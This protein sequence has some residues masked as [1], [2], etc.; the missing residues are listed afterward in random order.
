MTGAYHDEAAKCEEA[1][2]WFAA[3]VML[4]AALEGV[5]LV[6]ALHAEPELRAG[7]LWPRGDPLRWD[8]HELIRL[9]VA[10]NWFDADEVNAPELRL[11]DVVDA[12]RNLRNSS[13]LGCSRGGRR[14][15][16]AKT[17]AE[18]CSACSTPS[19]M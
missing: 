5:L 6:T 12:A 18:L 2:A 7:G 11:E 4:G 13:T 1:G 9:G 3:C 15:R 8:L 17:Y 16:S 19:S 14:R 10:A